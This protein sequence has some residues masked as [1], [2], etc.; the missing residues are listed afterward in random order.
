MKKA[1]TTLILTIFSL[2]SLF[3]QKDSTITVTVTGYVETYFSYDFN[4]P[5]NGNRPS[6]IYNYNRHNEVNLN[7]G[8]LKAAYSNVNSR[9]NL[10]LMTGT[11]TNANLSAE[12]SVLRNI[13]EANAGIKLSKKSNL[14]LDMGVFSSHIGFESAI[15][16]ECWNLTRSMAAENSPYF[17]SGAK[18]TFIPKKEKWLFSFLLLNG[19]QQIYRPV[20]GNALALGTQIQWKPNAK[21]TLNSSSFYQNT[22]SANLK[23]SRLFHDFYAI[24]QANK[25]FGVT[26]G[27]DN[28]VDNVDNFGNISLQKWTAIVAIM[29]VSPSPKWA[30]AARLEFFKDTNAVFV[31]VP[32]G[33]TFNA[34]GLSI[35]VDYQI[36][37]NAVWRNELRSITNTDPIFSRNNTLIKK[38]S[39]FTTVIAVSF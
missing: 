15:G 20:S 23:E 19:W 32:D 18:L 28:G 29:R 4:K 25:K 8:Y 2:F 31:S 13:L 39:A 5:E 27:L 35:N 1:L 37:K 3:A 10:A 12:P 11:Y 22:G 38:N 21:W 16:K 36:S 24:Y 7:L 6:F 9:A 33:R 26:F 17:E 30:F 14:W 34:D